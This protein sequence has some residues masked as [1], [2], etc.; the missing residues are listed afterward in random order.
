M[1]KYMRRASMLDVSIT[2]LKHVFKPIGGSYT[3]N[4]MSGEI[5]A[6]IVPAINV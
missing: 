5:T 4:T 3:F 1:S 2:K 6:Q